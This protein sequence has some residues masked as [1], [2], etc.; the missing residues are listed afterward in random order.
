MAAKVSVGG[1]LVVASGSILAPAG[2]NIAIT[3][4]PTGPG[5]LKFTFVFQNDGGAATYKIEP[6][7][8]GILNALAPSSAVRV[9]LNNFDN[10]LGQGI[11]T[12]IW[13]GNV[14]LRPLYLVF[15]TY[16]IGQMPNILRLLHYT[17]TLT[18]EQDV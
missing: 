11:T 15:A 8:V 12:P 2:Q 18:G 5:S 6:D 16:L 13:V 3:P 7:S 4:V 9:I 1:N 14:G 10:S 17:F